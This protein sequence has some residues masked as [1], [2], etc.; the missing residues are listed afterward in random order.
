MVLS[1][2]TVSA[3]VVVVLLSAL[4]DI[5][6]TVS[7]AGMPELRLGLNDKV[8]FAQDAAAGRAKGGIE[9]EDV[10]FHQCVNLPRFEVLTDSVAFC[11]YIF[12]IHDA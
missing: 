9:M 7:S 11:L 5:V 10:T 8:Q 3:F 1:E 2:R 4:F 12:G 6:V